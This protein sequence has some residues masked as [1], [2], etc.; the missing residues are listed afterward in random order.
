MVFGFSWIFVTL[1]IFIFVISTIA[2]TGVFA[3]ILICIW[4]FVLKTVFSF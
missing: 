1:A 4:C 3:S 2:R